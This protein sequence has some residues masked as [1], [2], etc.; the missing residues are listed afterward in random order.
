[1]PSPFSPN[2]LNV[3]AAN[4]MPNLRTLNIVDTTLRE[5]EQFAHAHFT[6]EQRIA[7]ARIL[8]EFGVEYLELTSPA[9]SAQ[10]AQD[11]KTISNLGLRA[12]IL[13]HVRCHMDDARL[14]VENGAQGVNM[15]FATSE[16]LREVSHGRSLD[17]IIT[18]ATAV[19]RYLQQTGVEVRF[20][21]EDAFRTDV[22]DLIRIYSAIDDL[23]VD[24]IGIADTV[25]IA[26]P[27]QVVDVVH[28]VRQTVRCDI[29]FHG[30][31][32]S[33]CAVAN[34]LS[35]FEAGATHIDVTV[36]GIGERN[37]I[38]SLSGLVARLVTLDRRY[39]A[40]YRLEML[41]EIDRMVAD[42]VGIDIPFNNA[43]TSPTAFTH[44]AGMHTKAVIADPESYEV[45]NPAWFGLDRTISVGSRLTGWHA[46]AS[47]ANELGLVLSEAVIRSATQRLKNLADERQLHL[48]EVDRLLSEIAAHPTS[49]ACER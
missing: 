5:G 38:T 19:I 47:R 7:I 41:P 23:G 34:A 21:C 14:A 11:L 29:E 37:G 13:T 1:M 35:A 18:E 45:L 49:Y 17:Q 42:F 10:S 12:K 40:P 3:G 25:G 20:S 48:D 33:G 36:L 8:D 44:K 6:T 27:R 16:Q 2:R 15:L 39:V 24:R 43:I 9:A 31:N 22:H 26:T 32:D 4:A 30:H 28:A 46:V